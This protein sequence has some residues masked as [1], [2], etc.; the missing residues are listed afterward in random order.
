LQIFELPGRHSRAGAA[1][2][3]PSCQVPKRFARIGHGCVAASCVTAFL[4][5]AIYV[6]QDSDSLLRPVD[7]GSGPL[8]L[9]EQ[10]GQLGQLGGQIPIIFGI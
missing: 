3:D 4:K 5:I 6:N 8:H 9:V 10:L 7:T 2:Y 1:K